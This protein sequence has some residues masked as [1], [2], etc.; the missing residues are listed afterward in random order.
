[1]YGVL[2]LEVHSNVYEGYP[3]AQEL[4][5]AAASEANNQLSGQI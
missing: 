1:M 2:N 3:N 4:T 5:K